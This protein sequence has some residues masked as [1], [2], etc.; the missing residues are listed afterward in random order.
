MSKKLDK[1]KESDSDLL[2]LAASGF[3]L[4]AEAWGTRKGK[5]Y[6]WLAQELRRMA[7]ALRHGHGRASDDGPRP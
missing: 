3:S 1:W 6:A 2:E 5:D 4:W 7:R